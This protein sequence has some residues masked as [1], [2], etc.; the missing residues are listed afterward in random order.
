MPCDSFWNVVQKK[1]CRAK[2]EDGTPCDGKPAMVRFISVSQFNYVICTWLGIDELESHRV[3][4]LIEANSTLLDAR[5]G[6]PTGEV[7][8]IMQYL[9]MWMSCFFLLYSVVA[10]CPAVTWV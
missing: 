7:I 3:P 2:Y 10:F 8:T 6:K 9:T 4:P 1:P 5:N